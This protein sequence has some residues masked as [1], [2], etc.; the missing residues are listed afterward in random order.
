[1]NLVVISHAYQN[2]RY[3]SALEAIA[4]QP[5]FEV[6][7]IHPEMYKGEQC[8]WTTSPT[9][10]SIPVQVRFGS[11]Q[12]T[13]LY[14]PRALAKALDQA[15]PD[16]IL[17]EQEVYALGAAQVAFA[18]ARRSI[19][20]VMFVWENVRRS[21]AMP[22]Q[23]L[24]RYVLAKANGVIAGSDQAMQVHCVLGFRG[25]TA[26]I[27][28]MGVSACINPIYGRR[29]R[30]VLKVCFVGR[31]LPC[32]GVDSLL[33]GVADLRR[34]GVSVSCTIA[35]QG[36]ELTKLHA[37]AQQL[38]IQN[39]V[40]F[41]GQLS[42]D[43]VQSLL[44]SSDVLVLPSRRTETWQEQFGLVLTEAMAEA[45][46]TVGSRTG[47]IPE[48]IGS[49]DLLF[50]EDDFRGLARTLERLACDPHNYIDCQ[51]RLWK[52]ARDVYSADQLA[53]R[54]VEFL[55]G[56]LQEVR[57]KNPERFSGCDPLQ[58]RAR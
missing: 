44:R 6:T 35:G 2:E 38:G 31:L 11:R 23:I 13:F 48:V 29:N 14:H 16:V 7:L 22:R 26:V 39:R 4:R 30:N 18:A 21:L 17:H 19:P 10:H 45:T 34:R 46:V 9:V 20:L 56:V 15:H 3:L 52:R 55:R 43:A 50:E 32:K 54:R 49:E 27:P 28:Q 33:R 5:G 24:S 36:P 58:A 40:L 1:M 37:V 12:G 53:A 51:H 8:A 57:Q 41:C 42:A 25:A 47:A